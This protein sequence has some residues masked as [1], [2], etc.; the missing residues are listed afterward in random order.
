MT[1]EDT[2]RLLS[3]AGSLDPW[4]GQTSPDEAAIMVIGWADL[5]TPVPFDVAQG[6]VKRHYSEPGARSI[7][8]GDVL[9]A[10]HEHRRV[11][12]RESSYA[13]D[14]TVPQ[15]LAGVTPVARSMAA[16]LRECLEV[17]GAGGDVLTVPR[18]AAYRLSPSAEDRERACAFP[19]ICACSHTECRGGFLDAE[20]HVTSTLGQR[21]PAVRF[22]PVCAD[23]LLMAVEQGVAR[24]PSAAGARR[25][26]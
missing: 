19:K 10:W 4:M 6:A 1:P 2:R 8:P 12:A 17:A 21:Y 20:E 14:A 26:R 13:V 22:C 3:Y 7:Q 16:Y 9:G 25:G 24:K 18:P 5:L 15:T 23:G 11:E